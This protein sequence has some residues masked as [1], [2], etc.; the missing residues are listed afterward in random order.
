[1]KGQWFL[2]VLAMASLLLAGCTAGLTLVPQDITVA[3]QP[4]HYVFA[5]GKDQNGGSF[6]VMDRYAKDGTLEAQNAAMN[7]G[8]LP[9]LFNGAVAGAE[10]GAGIGAGLA[11]QGAAKVTQTQT[12]ATAAGGVATGGTATGGTGGTAAPIVTQVNF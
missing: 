8:I 12:G 9:A 3:G 5:T 6:N 7:P 1:M 2:V 10:M 11:V 4:H